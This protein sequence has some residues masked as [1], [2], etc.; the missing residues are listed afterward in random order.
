MQDRLARLT[1]FGAIC[2]VMRLSAHTLQPFRTLKIDDDQ[3]APIDQVTQGQ[4]GSRTCGLSSDRAV[5]NAAAGQTW[6][7]DAAGSASFDLR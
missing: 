3:A 4:G 7:A 6:C 5:A 2:Y 1:T